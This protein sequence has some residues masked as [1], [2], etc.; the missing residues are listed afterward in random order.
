VSRRLAWGLLAVGLYLAGTA[1]SFR[2]GLPVRPVYDGGI[3]P[4]PYRW[5]DPP[6]EFADENRA[7]QAGTAVVE[8]S[9]R[10]SEP[11]GILT[12]DAQAQATLPE[13]VFAPLRGAGRVQIRIEPVDPGG[14]APAPAGLTLDG[15]AYRYTA[16]YVPEGGSA[17]P[18]T[19]LT[20]VLRYPRHATVVLRLEGRRWVRVPT[21]RIPAS[22][23]VVGET[24]ELGTFVAAA[25]PSTGS[26]GIPPALFVWVSLGAAVL[27]AGVGLWSR[28]R[29]RQRTQPHSKR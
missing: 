4:A 15:N 26:R 10:G 16:R 12:G 27:G 7:P 14:L 25:P 8:I 29:I 1:L 13:G 24:G 6:D 9:R 19:P 3:P 18:A 2:V 23:A 20:V 21:T 11:R 5:V 28:R 22:L 17:E